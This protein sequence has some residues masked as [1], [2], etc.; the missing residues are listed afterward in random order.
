MDSSF[1]SGVENDR[2]MNGEAGP[3]GMAWEPTEVARLEAQSWVPQHR[4]T[5]GHTDGKVG[6]RRE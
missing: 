6:R 1:H 4:N 2:V 5:V 3:P